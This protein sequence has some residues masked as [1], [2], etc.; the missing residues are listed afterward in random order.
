MAK[1]I[2]L[3]SSGCESTALLCWHVKQQNDVIAVHYENSLHACA[4]TSRC[5]EICR[6]L[7]VPLDIIPVALDLQVG[8]VVDSGVWAPYSAIYAA[9][10][11][12]E[13]V[14]YGLHK[15]CPNLDRV[16]NIHK[17]FD[18]V[19]NLTLNKNVELSA[20]LVHLTKKEQYEI[21]PE[22]LKSNVVYCWRNRGKPCGY[23]GKCKEWTREIWQTS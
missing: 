15:T 1:S 13:K 8:A 7:K 23:C 9:H 10:Y 11:R 6:Y 5:K 17:T 3:L 4:E 14:H 20:P 2:V 16:E 12:I 19:S 21:I 18:M 22:D